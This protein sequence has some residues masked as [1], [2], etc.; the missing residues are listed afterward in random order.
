[1]NARAPLH[2][3]AAI[4]RAHAYEALRLEFIKTLFANPSGLVRT[5]SYSR[6]QKSP[7]VREFFTHLTDDM[8][9]QVVELVMR[10]ALSEDNVAK[11]LLDAVSKAHAEIHSEEV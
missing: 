9:T 10:A 4:D 1:M 7:A 2:D 11:G 6:A 3:W 5:P 8:E